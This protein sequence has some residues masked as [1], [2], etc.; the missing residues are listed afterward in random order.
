M[1]CYNSFTLKENTIEKTKQLRENQE[2]KENMHNFPGFEIL[3][4]ICIGVQIQGLA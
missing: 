1:L 4:T 3:G 2:G